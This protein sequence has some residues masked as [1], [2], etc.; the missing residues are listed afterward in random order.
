MAANLGVVFAADS[1]R[2]DSC[3]RHGST[4]LYCKAGLDRPIARDSPACGDSQL[5]H[6]RD[7]SHNWHRERNS[8]DEIELQTVI[9]F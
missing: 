2:G 6:L 4:V 7:S 9:G 8:V 3:P 5:S 1:P